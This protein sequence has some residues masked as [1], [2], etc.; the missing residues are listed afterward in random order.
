M[1]PTAPLPPLQEKTLALSD[2][3][4]QHAREAKQYLELSE[5]LTALQDWLKR[6]LQA[7]GS[8]MFHADVPRVP[9]AD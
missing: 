3:A 9:P 5:Q 4:A 2:V 7:A 1:T 8:P 6:Q